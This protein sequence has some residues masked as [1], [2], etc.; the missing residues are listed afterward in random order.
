[1]GA[2]LIVSLL[3]DVLRRAPKALALFPGAKKTKLVHLCS[4]CGNWFSRPHMTVDHVLRK[5]DGGK[6]NRENV[7]ASCR[8]CNWARESASDATKTR[9]T[10]IAMNASASTIVRRLA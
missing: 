4:Y 5:R 1:M 3:D 7:V 2:R 8:W 6:N 9:F 10:K